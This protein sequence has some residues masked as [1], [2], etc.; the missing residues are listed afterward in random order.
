MIRDPDSQHAFRCQMVRAV[1]APRPAELF[2]CADDAALR[3]LSRSL[4]DW[5]Q[6]RAMLRAKGWGD[7]G[8]SLL[9]VVNAIPAKIKA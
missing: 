5:E 3:Q 9:E 2:V 4:A 1:G 8:S 7:I 6:A